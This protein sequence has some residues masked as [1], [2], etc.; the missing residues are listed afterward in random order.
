MRQAGAQRAWKREEETHL[1]DRI[2]LGKIVQI[3][4]RL[5]NAARAGMKVYRFESGDPS[6]SIAPHVRRAAEEAL[7]A[8][9]THY[10]PNNGIPELREALAAKVRS[11]N[12]IE[13]KP[14]GIFV[15]NGAM[16]ALYV[17]FASLLEPGDEVIVPDPMWTEVAENVRLARGIAVGVPVTVASS[18]AYDPRAIEAAITPATTAIFVNTPLDRLRRGL[19]GRRLRAERARQHCQPGR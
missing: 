7:A 18:Y 10:I 5:M 11:R 2:S 6:F 15:T 17:L 9:K 13:V 4:E 3:R 12:G 1:V 19:R 16:H 8:G 14:S